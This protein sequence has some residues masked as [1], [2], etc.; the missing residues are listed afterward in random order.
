MKE[1]FNFWEVIGNNVNFEGQA[2]WQ[3][4]NRRSR[5]L[6]F[7]LDIRLEVFRKC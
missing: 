1:C 3:L 5:E 4:I 2:K 6:E 7:I